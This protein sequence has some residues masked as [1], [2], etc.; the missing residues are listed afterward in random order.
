MLSGRSD[1]LES[2]QPERPLEND[3]SR[4]PA[5]VPWPPS[6]IKV[7]SVNDSTTLSHFLLDPWIAFGIS[8]RRGRFGAARQIILG[9]KAKTE[10]EA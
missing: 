8:E 3:A 4:Q 10:E 1:P 9:F 5:G 7:C 6:Q 2:E